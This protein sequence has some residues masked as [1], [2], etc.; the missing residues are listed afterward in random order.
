MLIEIDG[1][2]AH[3]EDGWVGRAA[4]IGE[5]LVSFNGHV[6]RCL[7]T[8]RHPETGTVDLPTLELLSGY[9]SRLSTTEPLAFGIHG[10]VL[11]PGT[12]RLGD[13]VQL[14]GSG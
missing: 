10:E 4:R 2:P 1:V 13:A 3:A 12:V 14:D 8:S 11:E 9:R 7:I 5:A 6:G